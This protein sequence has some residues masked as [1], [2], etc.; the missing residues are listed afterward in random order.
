MSDG[1][2]ELYTRTGCIHAPWGIGCGRVNPRSWR[3]SRTAMENISPAS[4]PA[5]ARIPDA[6]H[7]LRAS[8]STVRRL[9][10]AGEL[11]TVK[12]GPRA[13]GITYAEISRFLAAQQ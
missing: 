8:I 5:V 3:L 2:L 10:K 12:L 6:A 4:R 1:T 9:I 11:K 13:I 7:E